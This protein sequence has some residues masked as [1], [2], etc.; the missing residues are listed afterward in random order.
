MGVVIQL[1]Y[2]ILRRRLAQKAKFDR[3][4]VLS[5]HHAGGHSSLCL[6]RKRN[7]AVQNVRC[8]R[9]VL[10]SKVTTMAADVMSD[11]SHG[12]FAPVSLAS[13]AYDDRALSAVFALVPRDAIARAICKHTNDGT[14]SGRD[15]SSGRQK[16]S[17]PIQ[18]KE[19]VTFRL[20]CLGP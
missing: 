11:A 14:L 4:G 2:L 9:H 1:S 6:P 19:H 7:S 10:S 17:E 3:V 12:N 15:V 8:K 13:L 16:P 5:L 20:S 18:R